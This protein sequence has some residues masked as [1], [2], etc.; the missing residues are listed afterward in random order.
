MATIGKSTRSINRVKS[1]YTITEPRKNRPG[2]PA[3]SSTPANMW[4]PMSKSS[5]SPLTICDRRTFISRRKLV[6]G[7]AKPHLTCSSPSAKVC[8]IIHH[9]APEKLNTCTCD[10]ELLGSQASHPNCAFVNIC[11]ESMQGG[12]R[13]K[14]YWWWLWTLVGRMAQ[15]LLAIFV[16]FAT[17]NTAL[18]GVFW[19]F[20]CKYNKGGNEELHSADD[21]TLYDE[22][23]HEAE[24]L[25]R[26]LM[27]LNPGGFRVTETTYA[28]SLLDIL[29][30]TL[31]TFFGWI[32][33]VLL[34]E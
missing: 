31:E 25:D 21:S 32:G 4:I 14:D 12:F 24:Q 11:N 1:E 34:P 2:T 19:F 29:I 18:N 23:E 3:V 16:A 20:G 9:E 5:T 15:I 17:F 10:P 8:D 6:I 22:E 30:I 13:W 26:S 28:L 7:D 27:E 33:T